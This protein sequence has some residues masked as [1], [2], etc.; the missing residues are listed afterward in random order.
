MKKL[1]LSFVAVLFSYAVFAAGHVATAVGTNVSCNG[2][3]NGT[4]TAFASGGVGPYGYTWTGP[5]SYTGTG[6]SLSG[7][8]AGTYIVT[9][10]DSSDMSTALYTLTITQPNVLVVTTNGAI[11]SCIGQSATLVATPNGGTPA[12][13]YSWTPSIGLSNPSIPTPIFNVNNTTTFTVTVTDANGCTATATSTVIGNLPP[14]LN[15][16]SVNATCNQCDGLI[17]NNTTGAVAY[18]WSGPAAYTSTMAN[19]TNLCIGTYNLTAVSSFGCSASG[20]VNVNSSSTIVGAIANTINA[21]CNGACDGSLTAVA[22]GGT[23]PYTYAWSNGTT[24]PTITNVCAG[25]YTVQIMDGTGC[26]TNLTGVIN[27]PMPIAINASSMPTACGGACNGLITTNV[28]GGVPNYTYSWSGLPPFPQ[29]TSVC[30]G[31]YNVV[32]TDANGCVGS[33][34]VTVGTTN[35]I[36]LTQTVTPSSACVGACTGLV[37]LIQSG[38]VP[39]LTYSLN[40]GA[41]QSSNLFTGVCP[42]SYVA[43]VTDSNGC[44]GN[45]T[46]FVGTTG[47]SGLSVSPQITNESGAGLLNGSIDITLAGTTAPYTFLWSNG[48]TSEDIYSLAGGVYTVVITDN[49]GDCSS[50]IYTVNTTPS[51][52]YITGMFYND[53]NNNC[54]YDAGDS[55]LSNFS[56]IATNG[57]NS[58]SGLTNGNGQ[59]VI[60]VPSGNYTVNPIN[61]TNISGTCAASYSVNVTNGSTLP[62]NNFAYNLPAVYDVCVSGW[63]PGIVPGFN[64]TYYIYLTNQTGLPTNGTVCI[65]LP[66]M[67]NYVSSSP[68]ATSVSGNTICFNYTNLPGYGSTTFYVSFNTPVGTALG[69]PT[70]AIITATVSNGT[71]VNPGCNTYNY[72]R[73][74][75][76]S[77]DPNDKTVSPSG[78][79]ATGDIQLTET[80]FNYLVRFQ[81]TGNGPAVNIVITDTISNLLDVA[82]LEVLNASHNYMVELLPNNLVRFKFDNIN[83]PDSTSNEPGSHGHVQFRINKLNAA[84]AG[85]VI[86]NTAYIYF[87]FN[88]PVITNT[89]MNTYVIPTTIAEEMVA[90]GFVTVYPNPFNVN[91]TFI[92][93]SGKTDEAYTFELYDVLGKKI[94]ELTNITSKQFNLTRSGLENG[95][96]FYKIYTSEKLIGNGKLIIK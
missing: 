38:G 89:A 48:A 11:N 44:L 62:N 43:T 83:L 25:T 2:Q 10:I 18:N 63:S 95:M 13:T 40:G 67:L 21:T 49:N 88:E 65:D 85:Q 30:A 27:Q 66:P 52:G 80:E 39:P 87:D 54:I 33:T 19:P 58:Y 32:V 76:G 60:W 24:T 3:C 59:Y 6:Q 93:N 78:I 22:T 9:A 75:T 14:S 64:G 71:D 51:Y 56:V 73:P 94:N 29:H 70:T 16:S 69:T 20:F 23:P 82:S 55:P 47:I 46:L 28:T 15:I 17:I 26:F 8:C 36:A 72:Y 92:I 61:T 74:V 86:E 84:S 45:T 77:F 5:A 50:Y 57:T 34:S 81:N 4:A 42:G 68:A 79:G 31:T 41:Q 1:L 91:T 12:Y 7:L 35:S 37:N 96:Y 53:V 90:N